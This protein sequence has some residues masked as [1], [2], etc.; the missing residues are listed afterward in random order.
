MGWFETVFLAA[1]IG[2]AGWRFHPSRGGR[3]AGFVVG[4]AIVVA[5]AVKLG[6]NASGAFSDGQSL[7]W[8]ATVL[9]AIAVV[10]L[11]GRTGGG[12]GP[13]SHP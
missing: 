9:S 4:A 11:L 10:A 8:L 12:R 1:V 2:F 6:G 3:R 7:E 13:D 5:L